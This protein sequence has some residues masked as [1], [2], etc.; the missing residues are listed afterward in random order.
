MAGLGFGSYY[1]GV[2]SSKISKKKSLFVFGLIEF[3]IG[4]IG[5]VSCF[6]YYDCLY[7]KAIWLYSSLLTMIPTHFVSLIIPTFLMGMS[8]PFLVHGTVRTIKNASH[9]ISIMYGLNIIGAVIGAFLTPWILIP[10][11]G[12]PG[13]VKIGACANIV[14]GLIAIITSIMLLREEPTKMTESAKESKN[15]GLETGKETATFNFWILLYSL[16]GFIALA[17]EILWF[18]ILDVAVKSNAFTFGTI[19]SIYLLG[20]GLGT[21]V[22]GVLSKRI[23]KPLKHFLLY[24]SVILLYSCF[25]I[26]L[27]CNLSS[28]FDLGHSLDQIWKSNIPMTS[29]LKLAMHVGFALF[30]CLIPTFFMGMSFTVLQ[31]AVQTS[32]DKAG[33]KVGILQAFN[34]LGNVLGSLA[35]GLIMIETLGTI[36]SLKAL[37]LLGIAFPVIGIF[38]THSKVLFTSLVIILFVGLIVM[39]TANQLWARLHGVNPKDLS[40]SET[41]SGLVSVIKMNIPGTF[42]YYINGKYH[43]ALPF[44]GVQGAIG[45]LIHPDPTNAAIIGLGGGNTAW[46]VGCRDQIKDIKVYEVVLA[47]DILEECALEYKPLADFL[48]DERYEIIY[49]DGRNALAQTS[50]RFD[51]IQAD[52]LRPMSAYAGNLYS[53]EFFQ[54][55]H[56]RLTED[57]VMV[58]WVVSPNTLTTFYNVFP[59]V[60]Q[61]GNRIMVGSKV[62]IDLNPLLL[63]QT[64][65]SAEVNQYLGKRSTDLISTYYKKSPLVLVEPENVLNYDLN[66]DLYPWDEF[67]LS[68]IFFYE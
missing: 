1:G 19:L 25:S 12:I 21:F 48:V 65:R 13:S 6:I 27:L 31:K 17:L 63:D 30:F 4:L 42:T 40:F 33:E 36:G 62:P 39:P 32:G 49:E 50:E 23:Q 45:A 61:A 53:K 9:T 60:Y 67:L 58:Q 28:N 64:I 10:L 3:A 51:I 35:I 22:G 2:T 26:F 24:Q 29:E 55:C 16:S 20:L 41:N 66:Q 15:L 7:M 18:R 57:G 47:N 38:K 54:L 56:D 59:Y 37:V 11:I 14:A 52:A 44:S 34:I 43:S 5:M 46:A 8:L 68:N